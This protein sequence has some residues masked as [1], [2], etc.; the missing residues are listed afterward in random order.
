M[1]PIGQQSQVF[2]DDKIGE[3]IAA[4]QEQ[5]VLR[6]LY[7]IPAS[8]EVYNLSLNIESESNDMEF[9]ILPNVYAHQ[10]PV[11]VVSIGYG[12]HAN[13]ILRRGAA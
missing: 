6:A 5:Q 11:I 10:G 3:Y 7:I 9:G 8:I 4:R 1:W 13:Q 2:L 12:A